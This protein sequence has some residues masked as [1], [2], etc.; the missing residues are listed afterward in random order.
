MS[1]DKT[2]KRWLE[3]HYWKV[4]PDQDAPSEKFYFKVWAQD[5]SKRRV[6][7]SRDR[8]QKNILAFTAPIELDAATARG[9]GDKLSAIQQQKL[10]LELHVLL[11]SMHLGYNTGVFTNM[12]VQHRLPIDEHLS[13]HPVDL[14]AKEVVDGV[15]AVKSMIRKAVI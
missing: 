8:E 3:R 2:I 7:I 14:K 11:A 4:T 13:E 12:A 5:P 6:M 10:Y 9:I 1:L 15:I